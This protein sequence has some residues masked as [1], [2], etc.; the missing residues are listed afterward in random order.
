MLSVIRPSV[1][2]HC[3]I[4]V[5]YCYGKCLKMKATKI[6]IVFVMLSF[7]VL[8]ND[9]LISEYAEC[10]YACCRG[11]PAPICTLGSNAVNITR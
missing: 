4:Y 2:M 11:I 6:L 10:Q 5:E 9:M 3:V 7:I 1:I 8:G